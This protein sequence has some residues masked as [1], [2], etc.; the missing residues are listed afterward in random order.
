[1][2]RERLDRWV[3]EH[4]V[5]TDGA[6]GLGVL[7]I[8]LASGP[9]GAPGSTTWLFWSAVTALALAWRRRHA[10]ASTAVVFAASLV[11][12]L[13][14]GEV[15]PAH[16][17]VFVS[18]YSIAAYGTPRPARLAL[19]I[20]LGACVAALARMLAP[21]SQIP[22]LD[23]FWSDFLIGTTV[24]WAFSIAIWV[25]GSLRG[26]R[27]AYL[28]ALVDRARRIEVEREQQ[29]QIAAAAERARIARE[30]H[31]IVA[32]SLSVIILQADGGRMAARQDPARAAGALDVVG[33]T[34]RQA[35]TDMRRLLGVLREGDTAERAPQPGLDTLPALVDGVRETGLQVDLQEQGERRAV[36]PGMAMAAYRIV[37]ES[38][39]NV[40]K[41]AGPGAVATVRIAWQPGDLAIEVA[42]DGRGPGTGSAAGEHGGDGRGRGI[43]GMRERAELYGGTVQAGPRLGGGYQVVARLP[44]QGARTGQDTLQVTEG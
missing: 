5:A 16:T 17:A 19:A 3:R 34:A 2:R 14:T 11:L 26:T 6:L 38:L 30:L 13:T 20:V 27:R 23:F 24:S 18:L 39:T 10:A 43:S 40:M 12:W 35:L 8:A 1:M 44:Y 25:A 42:D 32:H 31:D 28:D 29:D 9:T 15:Q 37:Q 4:P 33:D 22:G 41:H 36:S 21:N 7:V